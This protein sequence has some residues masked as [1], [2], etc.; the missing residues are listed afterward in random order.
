MF[1]AMPFVAVRMNEEGSWKLLI[2]LLNLFDSSA[3]PGHFAISDGSL[4]IRLLTPMKPSRRFE[5]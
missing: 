3:D 1:I 4:S 5:I 2:Q